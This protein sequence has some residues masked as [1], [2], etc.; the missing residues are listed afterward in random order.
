MQLAELTE[1]L[2]L[3]LPAVILVQGI[4]ALVAWFW[5]GSKGGRG[6]RVAAWIG[7]VTLTVWVGSAIAVVL[8][9]LLLFTFGSAAARGARDRV[10]AGDAVRLGAVVGTTPATTPAA[11]TPAASRAERRTSDDHHPRAPG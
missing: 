7:L 11:R 8:L 2:L 9:H 5:L 6:A 3:I 1:D 4:I 10:H